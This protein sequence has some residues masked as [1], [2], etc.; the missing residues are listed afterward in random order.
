MKIGIL[1]FQTTTNYGAALQCMA[2]TQKMNLLGAECETIYYK[3]ANIEKREIRG[4]IFS[5]GL[6]KAPIKVLSNMQNKKKKHVIESFLKVN[7]KMSSEKYEKQNITLANEKYDKFV[8]GSDIIWEMNVTGGD[9]TYLLDFVSDDRKKFSYSSSF[10][11]SIIPPK[12]RKDSI[13]YLKKYQLISTRENEGSTIIKNELGISVPVTLDPTLLLSSK[14]WEL[15]EEEYKIEGSYIFLYFDDSEHIALNKA[16]ELAKKYDCKVLYL[17]DSLK[18]T[19]YTSDIHNV[20]V[21]QFLWLIHH[22]KHVVT[23][24]YHGVLFSINYNVPFY[25]YNRAHQSRI[26]T[27]IDNLSISE[28]S[29]KNEMISE[30]FNWTDINNKLVCLREQSIKYLKRIIEV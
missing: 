19:K 5:N 21:G 29:L 7:C 26:D 18:R 12:Y 27:I 10:G 17:N 8:S 14:E 20:S 2:L 15:Y 24:S 4:S 30:I 16:I 11:Y 28:K 3:C 25:Y 9:Y 1:T 22:A 6:V 13:K 23:G